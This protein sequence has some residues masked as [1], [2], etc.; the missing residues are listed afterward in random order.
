MKATLRLPLDQYAFIETEQEGTP[1][2]LREVYEG[3]KE[4]FTTGE[5]LEPKEWRQVLDRY[6]SDGTGD[7]EQYLKMSKTQQIVIQE[8]KKAFKR[9]NNEE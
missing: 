6:L 4:A 7:T 1:E 3:L 2:E 8:I 5:G 9:I